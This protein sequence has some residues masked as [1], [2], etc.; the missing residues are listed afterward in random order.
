ML[1][2]L[3]V[4]DMRKTI[5]VSGKSTAREYLPFRK[6]TLNVVWSLKKK[7]TKAESPG[8]KL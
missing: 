6:M 2:G 8:E 4:M 7:E 1:L 3:Y 5:R